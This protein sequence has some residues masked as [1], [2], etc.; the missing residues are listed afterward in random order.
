M[1]KITE[2]H[3]IIKYSKQAK[4]FLVRQEH[5]IRRRIEAAIHT[6]P[7][8]DVKKLQGQSGYRLRVGDFRIL[9][10]EE[11]N[12]IMIIRI[13]NRGQVYKK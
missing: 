12:V 1:P 9:F 7:L 8:G 10:D 5:K 13:D 2:G 6:L 11:G 3:S 4:K